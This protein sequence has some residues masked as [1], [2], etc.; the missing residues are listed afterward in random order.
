MTSLGAQLGVSVALTDIAD[1]VAYARLHPAAYG[2]T[3]VTDD[4]SAAE[5][6]G[7]NPDPITYLYWDIAHPTQGGYGI[8]ADT[9]ANSV[10]AA[11]VPSRLP[12]SFAASAAWPGWLWPESAAASSPDRIETSGPARH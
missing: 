12:S 5:A 2:L 3:N 8:I 11:A 1:A 4:L 9:I 7:L 10:E 6:A